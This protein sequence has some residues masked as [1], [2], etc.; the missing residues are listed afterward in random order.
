MYA[1]ELEIIWKCIDNILQEY[2]DLVRGHDIPWWGGE[3]MLKFILSNYCQ[4]WLDIWISC[5]EE[6]RER[7]FFW[8]WKLEE[9]VAHHLVS[10]NG[11][12]K[13]PILPLAKPCYNWFNL[14]K[15]SLK[16]SS[17]SNATELVMWR[18]YSVKKIALHIRSIN[19]RFR[20]F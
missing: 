3:V 7:P 11:V 16:G 1:T 10:C 19:N 4:C 14:E 18:I 2:C 17:T 15:S 20:I 5:I 8:K 9:F 12:Q 13:I 6:I